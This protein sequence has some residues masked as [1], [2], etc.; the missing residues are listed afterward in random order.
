M[1]K[2]RIQISI[3]LPRDLARRLK[4]KAAL[5]GVSIQ[6]I[7]EDSATQY[8]AAHESTQAKDFAASIEAAR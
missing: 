1:P 3:R 2:D 6:D 5:A 7:F 4:S 8:L